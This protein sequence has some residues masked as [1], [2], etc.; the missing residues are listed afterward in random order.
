ML[1]KTHIKA[2][3]LMV[4]LMAV[5]IFVTPLAA[6]GQTRIKAPS[7]K[8]SLQD[9]VKAGREAAQQVE[10]QMPILRD[11]TVTNYVASVGRRLVAAIPPEFQHSEF[12]YT[13]EVVNASDINAFALP[14]GPMYVNRGMIEAARNEGEMAGVMAHEI[15]HVALRHGTAQATKAQKYQWGAIAGA[16]AG[17]I[18]GGP[19]GSVVGQGSQLAIGTYFLKYSRDYERQADML[20]AQIMARAGYD[21][22]DLAN[23]FQT[24]ERQGGGGGPEWL[25]DHPNPGNRYQAIMREASQLKVSNNPTQ[26]TREFSRIKERL[27]GMSAAP[28]MAEIMRSGQ[29][30]TNDG[31]ADG[32]YSRVSYPSTRY[33]TY[34]GGNVFRVNVPDNWRDFSDNSSITFA[35]DGA[36]GDKGITHGVMIGLART[37]SNDLAQASDE[38]I[39]SLL[40]NN[41]YLRQQTGWRRGSLDGHSALATQLAGTSSITG[42]TE[43]VSVYTTML[44]TGDMLYFITV[45]PQSDSGA[46][47]K[48]F[49]TMLRSLQING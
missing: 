19:V 27:R 14:G 10:Q 35:P 3:G 25:S 20:G 34:T 42:R 15:S 26:D 7:N 49:N 9:D 32:N 22:R 46:F 48:A 5:A 1:R 4:W 8:Y 13:F 41:S 17:A 29:R 31:R 16:I 40:Q 28:T 21:P 38:Y 23:M 47:D 6:L 45:S 37:R 2:Q 43:V 30:P 33:R 11:S 44:R 39:R 24:I 36:F 18:I 12:R